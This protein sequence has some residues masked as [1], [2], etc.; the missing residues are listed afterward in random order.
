[1]QNENSVEVS[2]VAE[3]ESEHAAGPSH[4]R[5][6]NPTGINQY[7]H[8]PSRNDPTLQFLLREYD[9]RGITNKQELSQLLH[10]EVNIVIRSIVRSRSHMGLKASK[11]T[12]Q[13]TPD[14]VKCQLVPDEM[15]KDPTR[16]YVELEMRLQDPEGFKIRD[17]VT[18]KP[19]WVP[20]VTLEPHYEWS[21]DG[22]DKLSQ[23]LGLWV[24]P[25]NCLGEVVA[26]LYLSV[27]EEVVG[28]PIQSTMDCGS[29]MMKM[30]GFAYALRLLLQPLSG[31]NREAFAPEL[32]ISELP[33]H[34]FL[35]SIS[36]TTIEWGWL[37]FRLQ[38]GDNVKVIWQ[39]GV[40][41]YNYNSNDPAEY[42][43]IQW[44]WP[45]VIQA[46]L[47]W[48]HDHFNNHCVRKD[49]V[50]KNPS[51]VSPNVAMALP[52]KYNGQNCFQIV[53]TTLIHQLKEELGGADLISG[54]RHSAFDAE[55]RG[56]MGYI[57][58]NETD[59][60]RTHMNY[61]TK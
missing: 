37:H 53:D 17:L 38:W 6:P 7:K 11:R 20:L 29:E 26:Y 54:L 59:H 9:R 45:M 58:G 1:M 8:C 22:H 10:S 43:L 4:T 5:A 33:A 44:L 16:E 30:Y 57:S 32:P 50:K 15:A 24:V 56:R 55:F 13:D 28:M 27:V 36:N 35:C 49:H 25:S 61:V 31:A 2:D 18:K 42:E 39:E 46:E 23:W 19:H 3:C 41:K 40:E 52:H 60:V 47:D 14:V 51:S 21:G 34:K 12:T 48:L